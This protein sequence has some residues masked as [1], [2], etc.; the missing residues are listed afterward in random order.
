MRLFQRITYNLVLHPKKG[1]SRC[2]NKVHQIE[3]SGTI[4]V[5]G[6]SLGSTG[7]PRFNEHFEMSIKLNLI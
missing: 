1:R 3:G 4:W 7:I 2:T 6:P 5:G